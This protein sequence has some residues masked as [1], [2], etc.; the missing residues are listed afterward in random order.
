MFRGLLKP[1]TI[2]SLSAGD[3]KEKLTAQTVVNCLLEPEIG[4]ILKTAPADFENP[5]SFE[6]WIK[7]A[8]GEAGRIFDKLT[9]GQN[10]GFLIDCWPNLSLRVIVGDRR[11][12]FANAL[13][14]DSWQ[15]VAV[16][17]SKGRLDVY[18]NGNKL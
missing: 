2:R 13:Q 1:D 11:K 16:L 4:D 8:K 15:H 12:D 9:A 3:R 7:P 5:I 18:L 10:N 14:P 6:A 17:I